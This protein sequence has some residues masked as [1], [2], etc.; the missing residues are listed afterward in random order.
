MVCE[1]FVNVWIVDWDE[2]LGWEVV[3]VRLDIDVVNVDDGGQNLDE[4]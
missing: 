3:Q 2:F 4:V 1:V